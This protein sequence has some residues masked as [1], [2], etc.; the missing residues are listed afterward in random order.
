[1]KN[2]KDD[3]L[4]ALKN[5][6]EIQESGLIKVIDEEIN[7][8]NKSMSKTLSKINRGMDRA[9]NAAVIMDDIT[10]ELTVINGLFIILKTQYDNI[11]ELYEREI[12]DWKEIWKIIENTKEYNNFLTQAPAETNIEEVKNAIKVL[13]PTQ[14]Q[15][16]TT[17]PTPT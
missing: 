9:F 15:T 7:Q 12:D 1:M 13:K 4:T 10:R 2:A 6:K 14:T 5:D 8:R 11:L 17:P 16:P 3:I